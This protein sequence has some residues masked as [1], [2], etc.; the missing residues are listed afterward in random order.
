MKFYDITEYLRANYDAEAILLYGSYARGDF[1][2]SSDIDIAIFG[3]SYTEAT[4]PKN[5]F[6]KGKRLDLWLYGLSDLKEPNSN[7]LKLTN[8]KILFDKYNQADDFLNSL[9]DL[10]KK[11]PKPL[12]EAEIRH[13]YYWLESMI[14]RID[15]DTIDALYRRHLLLIELFES[16]FSINTLWFLGSKNSEA[17]L[18]VNDR[19]VFYLLK[20][21]MSPESTALD[22]VT[23][24]RKIF[25]HLEKRYNLISTREVVN[26]KLAW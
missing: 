13:L 18:K 4:P 16:Y 9:N 14:S 10:M 3:P 19:E 11:G 15:E 1:T 20:K 24:F 26:G 25:T 6:F 8:S 21:A 12:T 22:I 23:L 17:W 5:I 2:R 7:F